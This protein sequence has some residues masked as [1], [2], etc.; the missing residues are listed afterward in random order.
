V[1]IEEPIRVSPEA[2]DEE[3]ERKRLELETALNRATRRAEEKLN[4]RGISR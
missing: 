3:L 1:V 2:S 4:L